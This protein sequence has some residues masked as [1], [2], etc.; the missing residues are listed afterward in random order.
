MLGPAVLD[1]AQHPT[2]TFDIRSAL[3]SPQ[4][5]ANGKTAYDLVGTFTLH[6]V[7]RPVTVRA[8]AE[9]VGPFV[10]LWG[11]FAVRQTDFGM[12]PFSKLGG[13]VGVADELRIYGDIRIAAGAS[14]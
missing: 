13:V 4:Q 2:A 5:P 1:V 7:A 14:P 8:E 3:P 9:V 6:G 12:K 10:R 11:E